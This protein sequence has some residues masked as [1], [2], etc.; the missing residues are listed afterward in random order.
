MM[1]LAPARAIPLFIFVLMGIYVIA[2]ITPV[3]V[4]MVG[5]LIEWLKGKSK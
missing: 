1:M 3:V 2:L 5:E 4:W